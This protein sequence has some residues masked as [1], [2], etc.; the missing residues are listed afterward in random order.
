M[1]TSRRLYNFRIDAELDA[2]LEAL[3]ARDGVP[4][5]E[6]IRRAIREYLTKRGVLPVKPTRTKATKAR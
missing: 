2:G 3:R 4:A 5:S 6:A 1:R